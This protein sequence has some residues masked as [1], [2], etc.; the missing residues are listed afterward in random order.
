M[1]KFIDFYTSWW[2][3]LEHKAFADY[4]FLNSKGQPYMSAF[5]RLLDVDVQKVDP[6]TKLIEDDES[7]NTHTEVWFELGAQ[8]QDDTFS[9]HEEW[10]YN[11][12]D[13]Y[14]DCGGDTFEIAIVNLAN[15]VE[16]YYP[17][18][19]YGKIDFMDCL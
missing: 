17:L 2:Y 10:H 14:L 1:I 15:L 18:S 4:N 12:H 19:Q 7:R 8:Y 9:P 6:V 13:L 3:L 5:L 11:S 16:Q